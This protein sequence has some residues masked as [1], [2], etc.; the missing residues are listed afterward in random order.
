MD[1][2]NRPDP[3]AEGIAAL[4][5]CESL[6]IALNDLRIIDGT[7]TRALLED[8]ATTHRNAIPDAPNPN[9]HRAVI[10]VIERIIRGTSAMRPAPG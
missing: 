7:Q 1:K 3:T 10:A 6:L 2:L 4:S 5:I 8:A 9:Q